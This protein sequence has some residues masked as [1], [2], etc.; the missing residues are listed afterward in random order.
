M[1]PYCKFTPDFYHCFQIAT[2]TVLSVFVC[3]P[4]FA[5][6]TTPPVS[7]HSGS[8]VVRV[9][10]RVNEE[11][12]PQVLVQLIHFQ[13]GIV[14]EQFTGSDG[15]VQFSGLSAGAFTIRA[16]LQ[17]YET[18][19]A[20]VDVDNGDQA[21]QN[22]DIFLLPREHDQN[23]T[24]S[25]VV[26]ADALKIPR[27]AQKQFERGSRLLNE[28]KDLIHSIAALQRAT[29]LYPRYAD[30]YFLLGSAQIQTNANSSAEASLRK[31]IALNSHLTAAYYSLA[32]LL[33]GE[34]RYAEE[35]ELLFQA[36]QVD[37]TDWHWPFELARC[38]AQ[39]GQ[40][41]IALRYGLTASASSDVPPKIHLLLADIYANS[42][43]PRDAVEELEM[44]TKFDPKSAYMDRVR[45]VLPI[46]R[47]RAAVSTPTSEPH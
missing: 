17:N 26:A 15:S 5:R 38:Y 35:K 24:P 20:H 12:L 41:E 44:F 37:A 11:L 39:Q 19:D 36:E 31:A 10:D 18:S 22:V 29:E 1:R 27:N 16:A 21:A 43:K 9:R 33:F 4:C 13:G 46:L 42:N 14:G 6:P 40:W 45:E 28:K 25:G 47:Q 7:D 30:A 23:E 8:V 32:V 3:P 2:I 34:K